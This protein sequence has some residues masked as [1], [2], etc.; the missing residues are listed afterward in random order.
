[1]WKQDLF[2][3]GALS[4]SVEFDETTSDSDYS[5]RFDPSLDSLPSQFIFPNKYIRCLRN[6]HCDL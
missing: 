2:A 4:F 1:M 3:H 5:E 6:L